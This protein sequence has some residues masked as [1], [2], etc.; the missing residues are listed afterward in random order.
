[1]DIWGKIS[2]TIFGHI[3]PRPPWRSETSRLVLAE[4]SSTGTWVLNGWIKNE[5]KKPRRRYIIH[6]C[7]QINGWIA[8]NIRKWW[9][10][11]MITSMC[12]GLGW[13]AKAKRK[14]ITK[15]NEADQDAVF[16][17]FQIAFQRAQLCAKRAQNNWI[18]KMVQRTAIHDTADQNFPD[19]LVDL[20]T[21]FLHTFVHSHLSCMDNKVEERLWASLDCHLE[22]LC[23][24]GIGLDNPFTTVGN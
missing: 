19:H 15:L 2:P 17:I 23:A 20:K 13:Q 12:K 21:T 18:I 9:I 22:W 5:Q 11:R 8:W 16:V 4:P 1:M 10:V 6:G 24:R 14:N 3:N 7:S